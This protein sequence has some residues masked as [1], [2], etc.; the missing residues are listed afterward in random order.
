MRARIQEMTSRPLREL[1][2]D[3]ESGEGIP[4]RALGLTN[5]TAE[6]LDEEDSEVSQTG[7]YQYDCGG[8]RGGEILRGVRRM[9]LRA[10]GIAQR[11]PAN[12]GGNDNMRQ[13]IVDPTD[14]RVPIRRTLAQRT[15]SMSGASRCWISPSR[16]ATC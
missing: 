12:R 15:D 8:R 13:V 4:L 7:E 16:A 5:P 3:E 10:D 2:P 1:I 9:G 11:Q 14:E 6:Q